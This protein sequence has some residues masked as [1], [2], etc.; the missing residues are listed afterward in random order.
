MKKLSDYTYN[1][2]SQFGEDGII[3]KIFEI[4]GTS[5]KV[6]IEFGAWDGFR[7]SN[8]ANL[9]TKGWKGILIEADENKY[10]SLVENVKKYDCHCIKAFVSYEGPNTLENI[11]KREGISND[12]DF[13]SIDIDG[14]DYYV[15]E[16]LKE[17]EPRLIVCEYNPTIPAHIDLLS[18]KG[19]YFGCSVLSLV[20]LAEKKG[21]YLIA[22]TDTNCFFVRSI[23]FEK[24]E[25]YDVN[26]ESISPTKHLTY[27]IT[28]Y[29]G[30]Y[31]LSKKPTFGCT[32]PSTQKLRGEYYAFPVRDSGGNKKQSIFRKL[33]FSFILERLIRKRSSGMK[34][35]KD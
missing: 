1:V 11:L 13:L 12:I 5:S 30:N 32:R 27:F 16:S 15:F 25:S 6:C 26:L 19:N 4:L 3:E 22:M 28:G 2:Y 29:D 31:I 34:P 14:D 23:D 20:K 21:Y 33:C 7:F 10:L 24:F 18:E 17:L 8:T 9:W 35:R